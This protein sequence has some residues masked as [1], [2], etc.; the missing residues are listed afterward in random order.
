MVTIYTKQYCSYCAQAKALLKSLNISY[1]EHD[2]TAKPEIIDELSKKSG[3]RT[4]PQIFIGEKCLGGYS[5][6]AKLNE[7]GKLIELCKN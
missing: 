4:V 6:I 5:D 1:E 7:E 2:V 3:F